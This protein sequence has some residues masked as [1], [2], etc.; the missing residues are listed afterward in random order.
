MWD[1]SGLMGFLRILAWIALIYVGLVSFGILAWFVVEIFR[2][3]RYDDG[4]T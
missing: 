2:D 4:D 3:R 1:F